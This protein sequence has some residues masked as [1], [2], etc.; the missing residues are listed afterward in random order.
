MLCRVADRRMSYP[1]VQQ[2][3]LLRIASELKHRRCSFARALLALSGDPTS[4]LYKK[5][6]VQW[7]QWSMSG[8]ADISPGLSVRIMS[9]VNSVL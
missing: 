6:K 5:N 8:K 4:I 2:H 9:I 3:S 7:S 1:D